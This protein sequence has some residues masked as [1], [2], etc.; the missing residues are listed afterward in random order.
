MQ[1]H[2]YMPNKKTQ[3]NKSGKQHTD[4]HMQERVSVKRR[5]RN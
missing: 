3:Q 4:M 5:E 1:E 2:N